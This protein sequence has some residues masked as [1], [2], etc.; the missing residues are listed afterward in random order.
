MRKNWNLKAIA[1][2]VALAN[3]VTLLACVS[4]S[5]TR[6]NLTTPQYAADSARLTAFNLLNQ[7]RQQCGFPAFQ[8]NTYLDQA[9][10]A[11]ARYEQS[12]NEPSDTE[13]FGRAGFTG[14]T[15]ADRAVHFGFPSGFDVGGVGAG[16]SD[17]STTE[18]LYGQALVYGWLSGVYHLPPLMEPATDVGV[19]EVHST[20]GDAATVWGSM[21]FANLQTMT[22][23][24]PLT[25]PCQGTTGVA[26][27]GVTE[28]PKPPETSGLWGTPI[29]VIGNPTDTIV[30]RSGTVTDMS[31]HI[32]TLR[33]LYSANDPNK[34]LQA[35]AAVAY[36]QVPLSP[37]TQYMVSITGLVNGVGF[38]RSF[39][40]TTGDIVR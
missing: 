37:N 23:N 20:S 8:D 26:F 4:P 25:F 2:R 36:P 12:A 29:G 16:F 11:H 15:Y 21:S 10:E 32:I 39:S 6:G 38:S 3:S 13:V 35:Y 27:E 5:S 9:A 28:N 24:S 34:E 17:R 19:G 40:F 22:K 1:F 31:R 14:E 30:L 33:L 18:A 7:Q